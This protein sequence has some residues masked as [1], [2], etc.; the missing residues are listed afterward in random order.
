MGNGGLCDT[1]REIQVWDG[2]IEKEGERSRK[3]EKGRE[4]E[5]GK[6][7]GVEPAD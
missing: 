1:G 5:R 3:K 6:W 4:K 7:R 2:G